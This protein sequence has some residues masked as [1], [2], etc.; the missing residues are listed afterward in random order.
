MTR[1]RLILIIILGFCAGLLLGYFYNKL[2]QRLTPELVEPQ[3]H[4][5]A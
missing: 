4:L 2:N 1:L 5:R 3:T